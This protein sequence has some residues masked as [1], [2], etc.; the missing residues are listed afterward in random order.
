MDINAAS[1]LLLVRDRKATDIDGLAEIFASPSRP[2][3]Y[4]RYDVHN[5]VL[6]L[7]ET[8][9]IEVESSSPTSFGDYG[10]ANVRLKLTPNWHLIQRTLGFSLTKIAE[11]RDDTIE[12]NPFFGPPVPIDPPPDIFVM[13]PFD[14]ELRPIYDN[15]ILKVAKSI[16]LRAMRGDDFFTTNH[17][18][19][20]VWRGI[21][22]ARV[23]I[24][25]CTRR[26]P[27]VFYEIG[28]AHTLG[29]PVV[30]ITQ[31]PNDVP[32]DLRHIRFIPYKYTP[33]GMTEF[34]SQLTSTLKTEFAIS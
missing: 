7:K 25:D 17:V 4:A 12:V 27:N 2:P 23:V 34:E 29:K 9:L 24:A 20:D 13:M 28:V 30:L 31:R 19:S 33:P 21:Y 10:I 1:V 3:I 26:N 11:K 6:R 22:F 18:M 8:G 15:H 5:V 16:N 14:P 32:F